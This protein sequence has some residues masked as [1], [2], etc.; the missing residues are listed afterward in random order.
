MFMLWWRLPSFLYVFALPALAGRCI[1]SVCSLAWAFVLLFCSC[2]RIL[3]AFVLLGRCFLPSLGFSLVFVLLRLL[4]DSVESQFLHDGVLPLGRVCSVGCGFYICL[5]SCPSLSDCPWSSSCFGRVFSS[6][7][8][9]VVVLLCPVWALRLY[10]L[11]T[12]HLSPHSSSLF[13]SPCYPS[14]SFS[15]YAPGF[16]LRGG[17][18][19]GYLSGL[20][21]FLLFFLS[22]FGLLFCS[23]GPQHSGCYSL[24]LFSLY[25]SIECAL[26]SSFWE[27]ASIFPSFNL[28]NVHFSVSGFGLG[29]FVAASSI[30]SCPPLFSL[31]LSLTCLSPSPVLRSSCT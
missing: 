9:L 18:G 20:F 31:S 7:G 19:G 10:P 24:Y 6:V 22:F 5:L 25:Y 23:V 13:V 14:W 8:D 21:S 30:I 3:L 11:R 15:K 16:F 27:S 26:G 1:S 28:S 2:T 12:S 17:G 4:R 29:P